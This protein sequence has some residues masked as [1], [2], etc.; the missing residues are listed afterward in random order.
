MVIRGRGLAGAWS[1]IKRDLSGFVAAFQ[2]APPAPGLHPYEFRGSGGRR[3]VHLRVEADGGAVLFI[4]VDR[5]ARLNPTA[6][7]AVK[8]ALD[9]A[10]PAAIRAAV[11]R[12]FTSGGGRMDLDGILDLVDRLRNPAASCPLDGIAVPDRRDAFA[13]SPSAPFKADLA[14]TYR[15]NNRCGH[16]YNP[17]SRRELPSLSAASWRAVIDRLAGIGIPHLIFTGG[18]P[19]LV[20]ELPDLVAHAHGLGLVTGLNTNGRRLADPR[21]AEQLN[22]SGLGHVQITLESDRPELHDRMT[23]A[24]SFDETMAG[25]RQALAAGLHVITNTTLTRINAHRAAELV[26]FLR[27]LGLSVLAMNG[28]IH[29]GCGAGHG[30]ALA[31]EDLE[32]ILARVKDLADAAGLRFLWY[33]PTAYCRLSPLELDLGARRCNAGEYSICIEPDGRVL[34]CQSDYR[35]VGGILD[36]PWET[37]W[38]SPL[39]LKYRR[40]VQDPAGSGL[41]P[42]CHDCPDLPVCAGGCP[43]TRLA[44]AG[45]GA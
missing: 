24:A 22:R 3:R 33:S 14:L 12:G 20:P 39:F 17:R 25:I 30:D 15:C 41:P 42:E 8:A 19:T 37:I 11:R 34:P 40:R 10:A 13:T 7:L 43:L 16:C 35:P 29:A 31:E 1:W 5:T 18:E 6:A 38:N 26:P 45:V 28:M 32:P 9:G 21:L 4:D 36:D 27:D 23:G 44:A 2:P